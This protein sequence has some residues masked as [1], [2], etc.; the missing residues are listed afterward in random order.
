MSHRTT[1]FIFYEE[2]AGGW[3]PTP[4]LTFYNLISTLEFNYLLIRLLLTPPN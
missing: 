2:L 1:L 3:L 4:L